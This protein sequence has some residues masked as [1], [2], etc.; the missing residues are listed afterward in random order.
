MGGSGATGTDQDFSSIEWMLSAG[1]EDP[2]LMGKIRWDCMLS[3]FPFVCML[4]II[5]KLRKVHLY[6]MPL[7]NYTVHVHV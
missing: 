5:E 2:D 7:P 6:I 3:L 4:S 1:V